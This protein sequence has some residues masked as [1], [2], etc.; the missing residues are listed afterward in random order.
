MS[1]PRRGVKKILIVG[2]GGL[3]CELVKN[4][5]CKCTY[6]YEITI[7]D[8]DSIAET[9]LNRQFCFRSEEV[10]KSKVEVLQKYFKSLKT[11]LKIHAYNQNIFKFS[12]RF[13]SQFDAVLSAVDNN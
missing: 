9:N 3:G 11:Q 13:F 5:C 8:Y 2:A 7:I 12:W 10:G 4:L 1:A 6:D